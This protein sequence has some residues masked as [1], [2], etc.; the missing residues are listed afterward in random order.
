M[1][2]LPMA[3]PSATIVVLS[4]SRPTL[5]PPMRSMPPESASA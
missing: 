2:I 1:M 5:T 4:S 3:M